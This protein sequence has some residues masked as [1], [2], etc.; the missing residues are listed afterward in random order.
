MNETVNKFLLARDKFM[1]K[2][3]LKQPEFT[4]NA[5]GPFNKNIER[6]KKKKKNREKGD[7]RYIYQNILWKF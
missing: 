6:I 1:P 5:C 7:L 4:C 3:H 2:M